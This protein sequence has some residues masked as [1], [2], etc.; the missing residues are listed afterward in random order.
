MKKVDIA[1]TNIKKIQQIFKCPVCN[2]SMKID[3]SNRL[4]C[5]I[6]HS[7]DL[8]RKGY[9]NLLLSGHTSTYS[10]E[11]FV[12][13]QKV[14][15]AGF[16]DPLIQTLVQ[17]M[18]VFTCDAV[19]EGKLVL[20][21]GCGEGSH[22]QDIS[23]AIKKNHVYSF[24]GVDISKES[25]NM[26]A[27]KGAANTWCVADLAKLPFQDQSF[28]CILN[29]LSPANY[30]EFTRV[31]KG[32]GIVIKVIPG[33]QYLWEIREAVYKNTS[34]NEYTNEDITSYFSEKLNVMDSR[35]IC[36]SFS[37]DPDIL[38][39]FLKMTPL[40]W[41]KE[42]INVD[43]VNLDSIDSITLDMTILTGR[44]RYRAKFQ[45][46]QTNNSKINQSQNSKN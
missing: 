38:R 31:L 13:R 15:E 10:K 42:A 36:D 41:G 29:I 21:A 20:D 25:I 30:S 4:I 28:D 8:S 3:T 43:K 27:A 17:I 35:K 7:F 32:N 5:G 16:Y 24:I 39:S 18:E 46:R 37:V 11:L 44:R 12:A 26:A 23:C 22:L 9:L 19:S 45:E 2:Q 14:C 6:G 33:P 40:T 1:R 34:K